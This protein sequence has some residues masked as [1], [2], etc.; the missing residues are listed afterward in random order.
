[1]A[2]QRQFRKLQAKAVSNRGHMEQLLLHASVLTLAL[3][4]VS[5]KLLG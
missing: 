3:L 1:M 2:Q 5:L 4:V